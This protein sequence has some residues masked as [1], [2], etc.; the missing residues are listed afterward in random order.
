MATV[1][2][3]FNIHVTLVLI[4]KTLKETMNVK[5]AKYVIASLH[6][7]IFAYIK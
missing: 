4:I 5:K 2:E 6:I 1:F 7:H 3:L